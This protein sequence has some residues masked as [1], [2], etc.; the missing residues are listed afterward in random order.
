VASAAAVARRY[1]ARSGVEVAGAAGVASAGEIDAVVAG[2]WPDQLDPA[3]ERA[4]RP[5]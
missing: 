4:S 5:A 1:T 3:L 2:D